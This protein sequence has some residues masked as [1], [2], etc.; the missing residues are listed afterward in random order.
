[1]IIERDHPW[2]EADDRAV[3]LFHSACRSLGHGDIKWIPWS[4]VVLGNGRPPVLRLRDLRDACVE[5]S[6]QY[7]AGRRPPLSALGNLR[8]FV[9]AQ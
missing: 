4:A 8:R 5:A 9:E 6:R 1:M 2:D 3:R 7:R